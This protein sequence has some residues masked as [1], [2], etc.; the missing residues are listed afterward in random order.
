[1]RVRYT[2]RARSDIAAIFDYIEAQNARAA[3]DVRKAIDHAA[4]LA[5]DFPY[6]G[7][8][9]PIARRRFAVT[10]TGSITASEPTKFGSSMF[11]T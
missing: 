5:A 3:R 10:L 4:Q 8:P 9:P 1:M 11:A 7:A 6:I 2:L